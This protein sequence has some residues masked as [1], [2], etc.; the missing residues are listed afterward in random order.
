M[1]LGRYCFGVQSRES[2]FSRYIFQ[3]RPPGRLAPQSKSA[4]ARLKAT[5]CPSAGL[6]WRKSFSARARLDP[7]RSISCRREAS[8]PQAGHKTAN[9]PP[10]EI[11]SQAPR[12]RWIASWMLGSALLSAAWNFLPSAL[13]SDG[14]RCFLSMSQPTAIAYSAS[15]AAGTSDAKADGCSEAVSLKFL[16]F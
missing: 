6:L 8:S 10:V 12:S 2:R 7:S 4:S 5:E 11:R 3:L 1:R 14:K 15:S 16:E 13:R 9:M